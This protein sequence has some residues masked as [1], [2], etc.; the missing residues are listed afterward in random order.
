[1]GVLRGSTEGEEPGAEEDA[2][3]GVEGVFRE[4]GEEDGEEVE[5]GDCVIA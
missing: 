2:G 5:E 1:M 4:E 3:E